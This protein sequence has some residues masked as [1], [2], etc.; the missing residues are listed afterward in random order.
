MNQKC[1][2][3]Q[4]ASLVAQVLTPNGFSTE[5][6]NQVVDRSQRGRHSCWC[7]LHLLEIHTSRA[8][9]WWQDQ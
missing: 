9:T 8:N 4:I 7:E 2:A 1:T 3:I 6:E 5:L